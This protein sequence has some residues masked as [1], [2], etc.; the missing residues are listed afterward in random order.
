MYDTAV[1]WTSMHGAAYL[2]AADR[3]LPGTAPLN[4]GLP[5]YGLYRC[6]DG[7]YL[8]VGALEPEFWRVVCD[9]LERPDLVER[10]WDPTARG[11]VADEIGRR[12]RDTWVEA[13]AGRDACVTAVLDVGEA[14]DSSLAH[15]REVVQRGPVDADATALSLSSP[16]R[17]DGAVT[18]I[19]S[20]A[21]ALGEHTRA[22]LAEAGLSEAE[23]D[24]LRAEGAV[25]S[26]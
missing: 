12:S 15:E 7:R 22:V 13:F 20:P 26:R 1:A 25:T 8:A 4:G 9:V 5:C 6:S 21:P 14:L 16:I 10:G 11:E 19:G 2:A 17:V 24:A 18:P 3:S 23:I